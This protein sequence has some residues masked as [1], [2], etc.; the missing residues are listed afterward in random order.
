MNEMDE[1]TLCMQKIINK[2]HNDNQRIIDLEAQ[3]AALLALVREMVSNEDRPID[4]E[5]G[6]CSFCREGSERDDDQ[7]TSDC[8]ITRVRAL[9]AELDKGE[10]E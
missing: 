8:V 5:F 10:T 3:N 4:S 1:M 6:C 2:L 9:L 7:H